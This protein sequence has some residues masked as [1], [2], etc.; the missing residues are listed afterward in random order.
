M[1]EIVV[2]PVITAGAYSAADAVGGL[3]TFPN[4]LIA[5]AFAGEIVGAVLI[6]QA[7]QDAA[8]VLQLFHTTFTPTADNAA[9]APSDVDI[10]NAIAN[11]P[12]LAADYFGGTLNTIAIRSLSLP[13]DGVAGSLFGQLFT[14]GT[15]TYVA[16]DDLTVKLLMKA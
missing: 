11:I 4:A 9:Y 13:V 14:Q 3:L 7:A 5:P 8:M 1:R 6:D 12:F 10:V 15:P 16:V 2:T